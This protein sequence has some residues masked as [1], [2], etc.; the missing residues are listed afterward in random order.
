MK[1]KTAR[2]T[3]G[4]TLLEVM[5]VMT[6]LSLVFAMSS[7]LFITVLKTMYKDMERLNT[8]SSLRYITAQVAK[9]TL[10]A[11][12]FYIFPSYAKLDGSV[13]MTSE[14]VGGDLAQDLNTGDGIDL[15][16]GDCLVIV[17]RVNNTTGVSNIKSYKI[18][19]RVVGSYAAEGPLRYIE[20][21]F[22]ATDGSTTPLVTLLNSH[23]IAS[24]PTGS[25]SKVLAARVRG[26]TAGATTYG[27]FSSDVATLTETVSINRS[28]SINMEIVNGTSATNLLSSS[29]F[30]Y[31]VSPRR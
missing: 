4:Y 16:Y 15:Y 18:Y 9:E 29:S 31:T 5:V 27:I 17:T 20:V 3:R 28:V 7:N 6:L 8:N 10:D 2:R 14:A 21:N 11:T 26:R 24:N 30:N 12:E 1:T 19:Y 23:N 22:T 25:S 13:T